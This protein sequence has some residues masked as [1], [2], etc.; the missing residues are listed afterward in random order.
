MLLEKKSEAGLALGQLNKNLR[1]AELL[2]FSGARK[3]D[4]GVAEFASDLDG[5]DFQII[6]RP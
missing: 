6:E 5:I 2:R 4:D 3:D 1:I